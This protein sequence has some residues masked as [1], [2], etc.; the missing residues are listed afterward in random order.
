MLPYAD[1]EQNQKYHRDKNQRHDSHSDNDNI[2]Q[3]LTHINDEN[4]RRAGIIGW[5]RYIRHWWDSVSW[6]YKTYHMIQNVL[7]EWLACWYH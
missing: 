7:Q 2:R 4:D 6:Y 1:G 3:L 5:I